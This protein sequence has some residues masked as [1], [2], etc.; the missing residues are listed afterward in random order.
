MGS[1]LRSRRSVR[2]RG[3]TAGEG[4]EAV[5]EPFDICHAEA[6]ALHDLTGHIECSLAQGTSLVGQLDIEHALV[7]RP[8]PPDDPSLGLQALDRRGEAGGLDREGGGEFGERLRR[9][10]PERELARYCG[11]VSPSGS[12]TGR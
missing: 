12:R 3:A 5:S 2:A 6:H 7:S 9:S 4:L 8:A 10:L 1:G 11:W